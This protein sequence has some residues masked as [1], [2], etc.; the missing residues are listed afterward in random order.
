VVYLEA[1]LAHKKEAKRRPA[2]PSLF[3]D[4]Q[5]VEAA[6]PIA[7]SR[8]NRLWDQENTES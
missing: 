8:V 1:T 7:K 3:D 5:P 2:T 6:R 4:D